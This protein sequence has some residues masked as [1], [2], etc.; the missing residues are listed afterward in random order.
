[1]LISTPVIKMAK[2]SKWRTTYFHTLLLIATI[3]FLSPKTE[4]KGFIV[5]INPVQKKQNSSGATLLK[6]TKAFEKVLKN[7]KFEEL[8]N[9]LMLPKDL[10]N[11]ESDAEMKDRELAA[12]KELFEQTSASGLT[13][14]IELELPQ[15]IVRSDQRLFSIVPQNTFFTVAEGSEIKDSKGNRVASG[16][17]KGSGYFVAVSEN[18][19]KTWKFWDGLLIDSFKNTYSKSVGKLTFPKIQ[20]PSF[21]Q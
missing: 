9:Y 18:E 5:T 12:A 4:G 17:Y 6:A 15:K 20:K 13:F 11:E 7:Q 2:I 14:D 8:S 3:T 10:Q 19:G 16:K 1:M 21:M